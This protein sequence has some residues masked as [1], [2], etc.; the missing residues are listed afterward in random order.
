MTGALCREMQR[1]RQL[2]AENPRCSV[3]GR[4]YDQLLPAVNGGLG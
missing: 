2:C 1:R 4:L 3:R